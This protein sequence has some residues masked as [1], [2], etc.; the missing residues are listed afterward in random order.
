MTVIDMLQAFSF[1]DDGVLL[2]EHIQNA[3][4]LYSSGAHWSYVSPGELT[5][6]L[7]LYLESFRSEFKHVDE[8]FKKQLEV[9]H[10]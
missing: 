4:T 10:P 2:E 7:K 9:Y 5:D 6:S 1:M 3:A 8:L